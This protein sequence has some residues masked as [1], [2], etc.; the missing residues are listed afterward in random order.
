MLEMSP[1]SLNADAISQSMQRE[2]KSDDLTK[3][4][5]F[6]DAVNWTRNIFWL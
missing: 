2:L 3:R 6:W 5:E 1:A 4:G